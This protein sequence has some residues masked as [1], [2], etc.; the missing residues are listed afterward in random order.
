MKLNKKR[1]KQKLVAA[2]LSSF[3]GFSKNWTTW[4]EIMEITCNKM[5]TPCLCVCKCMYLPLVLLAHAQLLMPY[6]W[7]AAQAHTEDFFFFCF[8]NKNFICMHWRLQNFM[9]CH[10]NGRKRRD[11]KKRRR[12]RGKR[13]FD[14]YVINIFVVVVVAETISLPALCTFDELQLEWVVKCSCCAFK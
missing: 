11:K 9:N 13:T 8:S 3:S 6:T 12:R 2:W 4:G 10:L 5:K 1:K 7:K 14:L